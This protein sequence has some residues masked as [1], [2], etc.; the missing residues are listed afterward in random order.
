MSAESTVT[1]ITAQV[2][3]YTPAVLAGVQAA[4]QSG[5]AGSDK[6]AAVLAGIQAGAKVG[7][8]I[9][10]PIV[11]GISSLIDLV[12]SIFNALGLFSHKT[13]VVAPIPVTADS[14]IA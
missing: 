11:S 6:K 7:E 13:S 4:E 3:T 12:V 9:P 5:A 8:S 1:E 14:T 2:S 10:A